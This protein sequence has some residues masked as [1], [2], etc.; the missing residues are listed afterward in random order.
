MTEPKQDDLQHR[1]P[2]ASTSARAALLAYVFLIVYASWYPFSGWHDMG[3]APSSFLFAPLPHYWTVFDVATNVIGYFPFGI[4][5]VFALYPKVRGIAAVATAI[6]CGTLLS[7]LIEAGQTFLPSRVASNLDLLTNAIGAIIGAIMGAV[8]SRSFQRSRLLRLRQHWFSHDAGPGVIV[9]G[10]WAL[11]Q[12]YPLAFLFGHGQ[13]AP[14]VSGWLSEWLERPIDIGNV[15]RNGAQL[16]VEQYWLAETIITACGLTGA[17]LTMLCLLRKHA[18]KASLVVVV[19]AFALTVKSLANALFFGPEN[20]FAWLT[21]G[22]QGGLLVGAMM[23]SGLAF[24]RPVVQRRLAAFSLLASIVAVNLVPTN[25][26]FIVTLQ[27]WLQGKFLNFN[28]AA[29]FLSLLWP[30]FALWFLLHRRR[31]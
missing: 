10:L 13:L 5:M 3:L 20:A 17:M 24:A 11:A 19:T 14:I 26:Y 22:A 31:A 6:V 29:H 12:I 30:F 16:T 8:L 28:G 1:V 9:L 2:A 15:L 23:L 21:P 4:L 18:P 25:P 27:A 7:G